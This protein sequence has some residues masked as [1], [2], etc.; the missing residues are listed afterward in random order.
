MGTLAWVPIPAA[1][2]DP[3]LRVL[4]LLLEATLTAWFWA[5]HSECRQTDRQVIE[6]L[7]PW[8]TDSFQYG[9]LCSH[10]PLNEGVRGDLGMS[11]EL[12]N[13]LE[14]EARERRRELR[15]QTDKKYA[16]A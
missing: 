10:S 5:V 12:L 8:P 16:P 13:Q 2:K 4:F 3:R 15:R 6:Q 1:G 14:A 9:G 11:E 7:C